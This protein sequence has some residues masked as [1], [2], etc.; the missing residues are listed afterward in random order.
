MNKLTEELYSSDCH[1]VRCIKPNSSKAPK[2][3]TS[4][5]VLQSLRY[6]GVLDSI[7]IRKLGYIYRRPFKEFIKKFFEIEQYIYGFK[8]FVAGK[9]EDDFKDYSRT[10]I[11]KYAPNQLGNREILMG[12]KKILIKESALNFLEAMAKEKRKMRIQCA[13]KI[14]RMYVNSVFRSKAKAQFKRVAILKG[15]LCQLVAEVRTQIM[16]DKCSKLQKV[17]RKYLME[18]RL[19]KI[20]E[21][22]TKSVTKI[23]AYYRMKKER[24]R[25]LDI[26]EKTIKIQANIRF[27]LTMAAYF[28]FK[29]CREVAV[30]VFEAGW[31]QIQHNKAVLIQKSWKGYTVRR[32]FHQ[33]MEEIRKKLRLA[34]YREYM[35]QAIFHHKLGNYLAILNGYRKPIVKMQALVRGRLVRRTYQLVKRAAI[36]IQKAYRRHLRKKY[37]LIRLWREYRKLIYTDERHKVREM[38]RLC[39]PNVPSE[40]VK[41]YP[42]TVTKAMQYFPRELLSRYAKGEEGRPEWIINE[43]ISFNDKNTLQVYIGD[44]DLMGTQ[45]YDGKWLLKYAEVK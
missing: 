17:I 30:E 24:R 38:G 28:R 8:D 44:Y 29:N 39:L 15:Y 13:N 5:A 19:Q 37:Y 1:F 41:F 7:L 12:H 10:F 40:G 33:V 6:L 26:R 27:M 3:F 21:Q 18:K 11:L 43:S 34:K 14:K 4:E 35:L 23:A 16:N 42:E 32:R 2:K 36:F 9:T 45:Y 31:R 25:F 22:A 20:K